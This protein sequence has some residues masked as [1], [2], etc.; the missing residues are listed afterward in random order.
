[1]QPAAPSL[2]FSTAVADEATAWLTLLSSGEA[3]NEDRARWQAWRDAHSEHERAWQHVESIIGRLKDLHPAA[4]YL[5]IT[6][7]RQASDSRLRHRRS[8]LGGLGLLA[9]AGLGAFMGSRTE[10][11]Q[12][13]TALHS[14]GTGEQRELQLPDGSR[15]LLN[16]GSAIDL[17]FDD[18]QRLL[19]LVAGEVWIVTGHAVP[20]APPFVVET[21][22]GQM[23]ALGT[24][25]AVRQTDNDTRIAVEEGAVE[26]TPAGKPE[27]ARVLSAG[28][29]VSFTPEQIGKLESTSDRETA[30]TRGLIV[31]DDMPLGDFL[32][33]LGRYRPSLLR[34]DPAVA[35][36]LISGVFPVRDV[37]SI[38]RTLPSV[39][40]VQVT[41]RTRYWVVVGPRSGAESSR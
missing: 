31:A 36:Q 18:R 27:A 12:R 33:E 5:S 19:R 34:C 39:L 2:A 15:V 10:S 3:S 30:W 20:S 16:T 40:P 29:G 14:T 9:T 24:R 37:D 22:D 7:A 8:V 38:L 35:Q 21:R 26:V 28:Y 25:F 1:M 23:R 17:R 6:G 4:A 13:M 32:A 11:W 41:E